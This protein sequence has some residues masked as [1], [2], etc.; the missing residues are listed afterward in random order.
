MIKIRKDELLF[1]NALYLML[2][3]IVTSLTG[4]VFWKVMTMFFSPEQVGIGSALI[5]VSTFLASLANMGFGVG[6]VRFIDAI[7]KKKDLINSAIITVSLVSI[8]YSIIFISGLNIW[9]GNLSFLRNETWLIILFILFT[10]CLTMS[11]ITDL[12]IIAGLS[13]K[14]LLAKNLLVCILKIPLPIYLFSYLQGEGIYVSIGVAILSGEIL[15]IFYYMPKVYMNYRPQFK[16]R[17]DIIL[18]VLPFSFGN[19]IAGTLNSAPGLIYPIMVVNLLKPEYSAFFYIAWML[20]MVLTVVPSSMSQ[21]LLAKSSK[22]TNCFREDSWKVLGM[23]IVILIP[24]VVL[25]VLLAEWILSL[26]G[27]EYAKNGY[28]LVV[29]LALSIIPQSINMLF[30]TINQIKKNTKMIIVHASLNSFLALMI[31]YYL[32]KEYGLI[33]I[34]IAYTITQ[35]V[36]ALIFLIPLVLSIR[37]VRKD[38]CGAPNKN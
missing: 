23:S 28:S 33:G 5:A 9:S 4:F 7:S 14:Y 19:Y 27:T 36:V 35:Y 25:M 8:L 21:S 34:G 6:I 11:N 12:A 15:S 29:I 24:A 30:T 32:M 20:T 3:T 22:N 26:F 38:V 17:K 16:W 31:A 2:N 37:I 13:S 10:L 1:S 18:K